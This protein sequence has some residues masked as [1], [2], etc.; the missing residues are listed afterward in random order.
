[1]FLL[2][3]PGVLGEAEVDTVLILLLYSNKKMKGYE[4]LCVIVDGTP[5]CHR[6]RVCF[7]S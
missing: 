1:M 4:M 7:P 2:I 3:S 5:L 6:S